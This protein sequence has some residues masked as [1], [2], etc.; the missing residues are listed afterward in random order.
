[1]ANKNIQYLVTGP[2]FT[3]MVHRGAQAVRHGDNPA[4][5]A[6]KIV[7]NWHRLDTISERRQPERDRRVLSTALMAGSAVLQE[8][9]TVGSKN[10]RYKK[11][12]LAANLKLD[13]VQAGLGN[14]LSDLSVLQK[15]ATEVLDEYRDARYL[16]ANKQR[17]EYSSND[18]FLGLNARA[19]SLQVQTERARGASG[20]RRAAMANVLQAS[21]ADLVQVSSEQLAALGGFYEQSLAEG[22]AVAASK[23]K[24]VGAELAFFTRHLADWHENG[25]MNGNAVRLATVREDQP[26]LISNGRR[27]GFD[28]FVSSPGHEGIHYSQV[29]TSKNLGGAEYVSEI[30]LWRPAEGFMESAV[31]S[32]AWFSSVVGRSAVGSVAS[33]QH[34]INAI[35]GEPVKLHAA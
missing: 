15:A 1:M 9:S 29:K 26:H 28:A 27:L 6:N 14:S 24:G 35:Y 20:A 17:T 21:L 8:A 7:K 2:Q 16:D 34:N 32:A 4:K 18:V 13:G 30:D 10:D 5:P 3:E 23:H 31:D 12:L 19:L 25:V 33:A 11:K 22:K